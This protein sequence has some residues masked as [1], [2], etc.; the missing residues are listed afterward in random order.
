MNL[1]HLRQR[2]GMSV[3]K[4]NVAD[5]IA[6]FTENLHFHSYEW[7]Y[8]LGPVHCFV[9]GEAVMLLRGP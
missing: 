8:R 9:Q 3:P 5:F 7:L 1:E 6:D 4:T 2:V